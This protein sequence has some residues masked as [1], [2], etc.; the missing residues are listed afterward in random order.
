[1]QSIG[2]YTKNIWPS[3]QNLYFLKTVTRAKKI[4]HEIFN[5]RLKIFVVAVW[6]QW[7]I[8][9]RWRCDHPDHHLLHPVH[10]AE[11]QGSWS[12]NLPSGEILSGFSHTVTLSIPLLLYYHYY[13]ALPYTGC[14]KYNSHSASNSWW[15]KTTWFYWQGK[16][17]FNAEGLND[18]TAFFTRNMSYLILCTLG[19]ALVLVYSWLG[20]Q[21][22]LYP[23]WT[24]YE[25]WDLITT[26][27]QTNK[28]LFFLN[29]SVYIRPTI[30]HT[31]PQKE[32][33]AKQCNSKAEIIGIFLKASHLC[34]KINIPCLQSSL[35]SYNDCVLNV[36]CKLHV[37]PMVTKLW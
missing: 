8:L 7:A 16:K 29:I 36:F 37:A 3:I 26:K 30:A 6:Y 13:T 5:I 24:H 19:P 21:L 22:T 18:R 35:L 20:E 15:K 28:S 31:L 9:V 32:K 1:M 11:D 25:S 2:L 12:Q 33:K 17:V 34:N 10:Y 23:V 14:P 27:L 4:L